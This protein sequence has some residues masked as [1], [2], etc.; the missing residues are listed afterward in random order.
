M[1]DHELR[2]LRM[3][4]GRLIASPTGIQSEC[5]LSG[6]DIVALRRARDF[7]AEAM[8]DVVEDWED[9]AEVVSFEVPG[10]PVPWQRTRGA[11]KRRFSSKEQVAYQ[12]DVK[13]HARYAMLRRPPAMGPLPIHVEVYTEDRRVRDL[14]NVVKQISDSLNGIVWIDDAQVVS[15]QASKQCVTKGAGG[16]EVWVHHA[17]DASAVPPSM[18]PCG[19]SKKSARVISK[20][21]GFR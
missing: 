3:A 14:D 6:P 5:Q 10:Q 8:D 18:M 2:A 15:I 17:K 11:G 4:V 16:V 12:R 9:V 21:R 19:Y 20:K 1:T 13:S 7:Y